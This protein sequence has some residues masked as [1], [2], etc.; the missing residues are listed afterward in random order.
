MHFTAN[1]AKYRIL[2][3]KSYGVSLFGHVLL[4]SESVNLSAVIHLLLSILS[5]QCSVVEA[6]KKPDNPFS[7]SSTAALAALENDHTPAVYT[8][9]MINLYIF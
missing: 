6:S 7:S 3:S 5:L 2:L 4:D 9:D 8:L 1:I